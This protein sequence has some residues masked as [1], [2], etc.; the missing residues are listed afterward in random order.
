MATRQSN[1]VGQPYS[2][3]TLRQPYVKPPVFP[4]K[5]LPNIPPA[6]RRSENPAEC[7]EL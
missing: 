6:S 2:G 1:D 4:G 5:A 3:F 7:L